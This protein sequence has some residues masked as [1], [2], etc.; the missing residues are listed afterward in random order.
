[1]ALLLVTVSFAN[2][3]QTGDLGPLSLEAK[4]AKDLTD[5]SLGVIQKCTSRG[6]RSPQ[7]DAPTTTTPEDPE[8]S[9]LLQVKALESAFNLHKDV[10]QTKDDFHSSIGTFFTENNEAKIVHNPLRSTA[11][12]AYGSRRDFLSVGTDCSGM[13]APILALKG[14]RVHFN[15]MFSCDNCPKVIRTI[16]ANHDPKVLYTDVKGRDNSTTPYVD[17]YVAGFPC[18][19][20]SQA[21]KQQGFDDA[22]G[23]G[24]I[25]FDIVDYIDFQRPKIFILENVKGLVTME[26]AN[27]LRR[28]WKSCATL[29]KT[30]PMRTV[31][32]EHLRMTFIIRY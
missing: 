7:G 5:P 8:D 25:F 22:K 17:L 10:Y 6:T 32:A 4:Y 13:E 15:H 30:S 23:R 26:M 2:G 27:I 11:L 3:I 1:M 19:P 29:E 21:G 16:Q 9:R 31:R 28:Y 12:S 20:F 24:K 18:Q 14:L